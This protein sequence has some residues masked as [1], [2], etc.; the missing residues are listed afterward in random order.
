MSSENPDDHASSGGGVL[1]RS[2]PRNVYEG[3]QQL[4]ARPDLLENAIVL[5]DYHPTSQERKVLSSTEHD[6]AAVSEGR[7]EQA[8]EAAAT[9]TPKRENPFHKSNL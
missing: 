2:L 1:S 5:A 7:I 8:V 9:A 3:G 4:T 6:R